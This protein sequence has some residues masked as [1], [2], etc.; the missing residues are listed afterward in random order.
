MRL[1][2]NI[3]AGMDVHRAGKAVLFYKCS[4]TVSLIVISERQHAR[5]D[6]RKACWGL[7]A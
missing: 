1:I 5:N 6:K 2:L 7:V 4:E 3:G